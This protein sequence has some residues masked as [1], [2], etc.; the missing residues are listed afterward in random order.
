MTADK[1]IELTVFVPGVIGE[2]EAGPIGAY[3][4]KRRM[5]ANR[6]LGRE[7]VLMQRTVTTGPWVPVEGNE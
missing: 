7:P 1:R 6:E 3:L 4:A 2:D 5:A